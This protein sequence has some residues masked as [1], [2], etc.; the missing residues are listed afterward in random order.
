MYHR[1]NTHNTDNQNWQEPFSYR[2]SD[3]P[4]S[5]L[6]SLQKGKHPIIKVINL[7]GMQGDSAFDL[8]IA[9]VE[10]Q[11]QSGCMLVIHGQGLRSTKQ[12]PIIKQLI[13]DKLPQVPRVIAMATALQKDGGHGAMYILL[14][15]ADRSKY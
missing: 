4:H 9:E 15:R 14:K 13:I 8:L 11:A 2:T 12:T 3:T 1:S 10:Q 7:R 6:K 5:T